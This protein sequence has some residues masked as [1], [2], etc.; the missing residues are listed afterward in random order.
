MTAA[1]IVFVL[2]TLWW[3]LYLAGIAARRG[4]PD[5]S[6]RAD[7]V[8]STR[9]APLSRLA[10][11]LHSVLIV[12]M[13]PLLW[14]ATSA[15][16]AF[17]GAAGLRKAAAAVLLVGGAGLVGWTTRS[18][19]SYRLRAH[20]DPGHELST[21][22]PFRYVRHPIY[23]AF[24]LLGTGTAL[25]APTPELIATAVG[26]AAVGDWRAR[27]EERLLSVGFGQRYVEYMKT[28]RRLLPR[29]Y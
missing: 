29:V 6:A 16:T 13:Y 27:G 28:T 2:H 9:A 20:L 23:L 12:G 7:T 24:I 10:V 26:L 15:P 19:R 11:V 4:D 17:E 18:F 5:R 22:G 25:W 14:S 1:R 8:A 21:D 3:C